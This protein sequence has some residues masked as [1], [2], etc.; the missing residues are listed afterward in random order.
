V[1]QAVKFGWKQGSSLDQELIKTLLFFNKQVYSRLKKFQKP[2][3][4]LRNLYSSSILTSFQKPNS[5][6]RN[7]YSSSIL[8]SSLFK[9]AK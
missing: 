4:C 1:K 3:S 8:T 2:N 6:L 7:P 9:R 5:C